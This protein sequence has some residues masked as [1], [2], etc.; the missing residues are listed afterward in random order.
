[1]NAIFGT[2]DSNGTHIDT[3]NTLRGAKIYATRN[4][5]NV[6]TKRIGYNA[7]VVAK[8]INGKWLDE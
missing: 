2:L 5:F 8:K 7:R 4:G 6:V 3:S 1:M